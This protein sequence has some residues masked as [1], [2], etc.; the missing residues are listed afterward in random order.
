MKTK[1]GIIFLILAAMLILPEFGC[2]DK[3]ITKRKFTGN[4]PVYMTYETLRSYPV[5]SAEAS[6]IGT[7]GKLFFYNNYIFVNEVFKGIHIIN[8]TDPSNPQN[9]GFIDIPGNVDMAVKNNVL[10]ADS[11]V[12]LLAFDIS[13][14]N[15]VSL[16]TRIND[17][18]TYEIPPYDPNFPVATI[19]PSQGLVTGYT[20]GEVEE[21][22]IEDN[23]NSD[24]WTLFG[25]MKDDVSLAETNSFS[26]GG[27]GKASSV[28]IAGSLARFMVY[29][30]YLYTINEQE[31]FVFDLSNNSAPVKTSNTV[32]TWWDIETLFS[33][34]NH[35]FVGSRN[36]MLI[37]SLAQASNPTYVSSIS[38][39]ESCDP[40]VVQGN[41]AF[42]T[43]RAGNDCGN[44]LSQLDVIDITNYSNPQLLTSYAMTE[45]YGLGIDDE[46]LFIC[47]GSAGLKIYNVSDLYSINQNM[48]AHFPNINTFD[49]IPHNNILMMIGSDGLY[50][51]DY[52][53]LQNIQLLSF[54]GIGE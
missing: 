35:L 43:L 48:I 3:V 46:V 34:N 28:A 42:V 29:Q 7:P 39:L 52:S 17:V 16:L 50:Q 10:Y 26:G 44:T 40:V 22:F 6:E 15:N 11:Y 20:I 25:G 23:T 21:R 5:G 51:Y 47:D 41:T 53:D 38:H 36:G 30:D 32:S 12:D 14:M 33:Y 19:D 45:P 49:V 4:I 24:N 37:Y 18:F 1:N 27:D 8:N 13:D 2:T 31:I 9:I 54:I